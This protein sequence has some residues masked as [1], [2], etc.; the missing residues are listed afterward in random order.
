ME[1]SSAAPAAPAAASPAPASTEASPAA[2]AAPAAFDWNSVG[3]DDGGKA[4]IAER[5]F[6]G[7]GDLLTSYRQLDSAFGVPPERLIKLPAARDAGDPKAWNDVYTKL[8]RPETP[9]K[10]VI[11]VPEGDKGEF[12]NEIRP[13]LHEIGLGQSQVTKLSQWWNGKIAE[14][15][16]SQQKATE[17]KNVADV[18]ALKQTWGGEYDTKAG[19]VDKAAETFGMTQEQLNGLKASMGPKAAMEFIYNIGSRLG[20]EDTKVPGM[21]GQGSG[22]GRMTPEMAKA[23]INEYA[24]PGSGFAQLMESKDQKQRMEAHAEWNY[25]H[26]VA[27]GEKMN[28]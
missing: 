11:P 8:G 13:I 23:K 9:D 10:Y 18:S 22:F 17:A 1:A 20:V 5:Q 25:L 19:L 3:L 24:K 16:E 21:S 15:Q 4:F 6:T 28:T 2:P 12:A 26:Q 14:N 27:G 7:P